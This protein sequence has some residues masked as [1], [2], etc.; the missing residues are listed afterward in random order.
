MSTI[1]PASGRYQGPQDGHSISEMT[2]QPTSTEDQGL[3]DGANKDREPLVLPPTQEKC[4]HP[5]TD[6]ALANYSFVYS[7]FKHVVSDKITTDGYGGA[8]ERF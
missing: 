3:K 2:I 8:Y 7:L 6:S 1:Q 5:Q 4:Y